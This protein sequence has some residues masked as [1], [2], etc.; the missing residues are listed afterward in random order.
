MNKI[1]RSLKKRVVMILTS[2]E[3]SIIIGT[4]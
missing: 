2:I 1:V 4:C 3:I